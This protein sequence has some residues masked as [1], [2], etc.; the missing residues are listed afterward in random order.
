[1]PRYSVKLIRREVVAEGTLAFCFE[2]PPGF[3][4]KA[5]Q[6][7]ELTLA[8]PPET[9]AEGNGRAFSIASAPSEHHL[10][11]ATRMR[12]TAFKRVLG[13]SPLGAVFQ[14]EGPFGNL[15]LHSNSAR[16]A[17]FLAGG[18][19][20]T[21]FRSIVFRAAK[22]KVPHRLFLFYSNRRPEDAAFLA[23][24]Q[25]LRTENANYTLVDTMTGMERGNH[26]WKGET[27][28]FS[29]ELLI[30][31]LG[32]LKGPIYYAAGPPAM[33]GAMQR[34]LNAAGVNDDDIRPEEFAGY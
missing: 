14:I 26:L 30:Q 4:F 9:D 33:V 27:R 25:S 5:G 17:V 32:D 8:N 34:L 12:D 29:K 31:H 18:I 24:L 16:A 22:E 7:L 15:V 6:F 13:R 10:T 2:K 23:E 21:P 20:I 1:L 19:G 3:T 28:R 11:V